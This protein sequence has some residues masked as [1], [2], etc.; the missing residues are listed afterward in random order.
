[1]GTQILTQPQTFKNAS[2]VMGAAAGLSAVSGLTVYGDISAS[3]TIYGHGAVPIKTYSTFNGSVSTIA[4]NGFTNTTAMNYM[5]YL[6]GVKQVADI[7]YSLSAT[8]TGGQIVFTA[9]PA[10]G[11]AVDVTSYQSPQ[12][13]YALS[14]V[15][16]VSNDFTGNGTVSAYA[17][18]GYTNTQAESYLVHVGGLYQ[19]PGVNY[20]ASAGNI[21]FTTPPPSGAPVTILAYQT[22]PGNVTYGSSVP[23]SFSVGSALTVGGK[24]T[25]SGGIES[26]GSGG[27]DTNTAVGKNAMASNTTGYY[28]VGVGWGTLSTNLTGVSNT[29]VGTAA[30]QNNTGDLNTAIGTSALQY[31]TAGRRNVAVGTNAL[32]YNTTGNFNVAVGDNSAQSNTTGYQNVAVGALTLRD[33]TTGTNNTGCGQGSL[34]LNTTGYSNTSIGA[35]AMEQNTSGYLNSAV[36][37]FALRLNTTGYYN[38]AN[39]A[40]ALY[41]NTTGSN[42]VAIGASSGI[43][44]L[45]NLTTQSN[46]VVIG[47]AST[48][49]AV[50]KVAWT[51]GS[52]MRDKTN[53]ADVPHGLDFVKELKPTAFEYK[54]DRE[55]DEPQVDGRLRYGFLAQDILALEGEDAVIV[56]NRDPEHLKV[57]ETSLIPVLVKAIQELNAKVEAQAAEITAL[58]ASK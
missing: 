31:N 16:P 46:Y 26:P 13:A 48:T 52:D 36:G 10:S 47:N 29:A 42:N 33:N 51:V 8:S 7:D 14:G 6:D 45:A 41:N 43:D 50:V 20:T 12:A 56:D 24:L 53:F 5:V 37:L 15:A 38:V 25:V 3:G 49:N 58:K 23:G 27:I 28:N 4:V 39:G 30:L 57:T 19:R 2:T 9:V 22:M 17:I 40:S 11:V 35:A 1:M 18:N 44:G 32:V 55:S 54:K 21:T 34:V